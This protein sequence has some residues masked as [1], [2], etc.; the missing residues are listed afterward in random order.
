MLG[1]AAVSVV[2]LAVNHYNGTDKPILAEG[3]RWA[4]LD[5]AG[6]QAFDGGDYGRAQLYFD[7]ANTRAA[8]EPDPQ[9]YQAASMNELL[10]LDRAM[11]QVE[12]AATLAAKIA[13][14]EAER[15]EIAAEAESRLDERIAQVEAHTIVPKSEIAALLNSAVDI[16]ASMT[17]TGKFNGSERLIERVLR[18]GK[19]TVGADDPAV[20]K[21]L[22]YRARNYHERGDYAQALDEYKRVLELATHRLSA[23]D[24][25]LASTLMQLGGLGAQTDL[26]PPELGK[27]YL[28]NALD[29]YRKTLDRTPTDKVASCQLYLGQIYK[30]LGDTAQAKQ[31]ANSALS[32]IHALPVPSPIDEA[33]CYL[34]LG[35]LDSA[36]ADYARALSICESA[37]KKQY[38]V[39]IDALIGVAST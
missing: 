6:Q 15:R 20:I 9:A 31:Q 4:E 29:I 17:E 37:T 30:K 19:Q 32:V 35:S 3:A 12:A 22:F 14:I 27:N 13:D 18:L 10:D 23:D 2:S 28:I 33:R 7:R 34:L 24:P 39:L 21:A 5:L 25:L 11:D 38:R 26:V 8:T 1:L 36:A 16:A